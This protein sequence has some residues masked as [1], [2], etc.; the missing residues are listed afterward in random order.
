MISHQ[1][2]I[3]G[4]RSRLAVRAGAWSEFEPA[5]V[6]EAETGV[7][8]RA[9][10]EHGSEDASPLIEVVVDF[11]RGLVLTSSAFRPSRASRARVLDIY[12]V[13]RVQE[14]AHMA[15]MEVIVRRQD[16]KHCA[17]ITCMIRHYVARR[18]QVIEDHP[19][20]CRVERAIG[21]IRPRTCWRVAHARLQMLTQQE[22]WHSDRS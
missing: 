6:G 8:G 21:V 5:R 20:K 2:N 9:F 14:R 1:R 19:H 10:G 15:D 3:Y 11:G 7:A 17:S 4:L 18:A 13:H 16:R 12:A 22:P